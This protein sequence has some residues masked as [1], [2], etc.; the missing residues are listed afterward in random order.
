MLSLCFE[1][2]EISYDKIAGLVLRSKP[3]IWKV[4]EVD[5]VHWNHNMIE[6][7]QFNGLKTKGPEVDGQY[8]SEE[9]W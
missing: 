7:N 5:L 1:E 9:C 8:S 3:K 6:N 4:N 2:S